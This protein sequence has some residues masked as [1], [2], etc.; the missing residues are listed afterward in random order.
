MDLGRR[1]GRVVVSAV[2]R[3][4]RR[5]VRQRGEPTVSRVPGRYSLAMKARS[6]LYAGMTCSP[7]ASGYASVS[8]CV[9]G[10]ESAGHA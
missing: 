9:R 8:R 10:R 3:V 4:P 5:A 7:I 6:R 1:L 2:E